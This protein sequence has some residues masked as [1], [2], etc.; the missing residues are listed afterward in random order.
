WLTSSSPAAGAMLHLA[1]HGD[2]VLDAE[3]PRSMLL[4]AGEGGGELDA[5][6]LVGVMAGARQRAIDLVVLAACR[7]GTSIHGYD[8]AYS[9]GTA[10]LAGGARSVLSTQW[11]IPDV[12]TSS[13]MFMFHYYLR[14]HQ[15]PAWRAL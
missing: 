14:R 12:A 9:M 2:V 8:E 6:E 3:A 7:T 13:L 10:F 11:A 15:L 1:C 5:E 4:L